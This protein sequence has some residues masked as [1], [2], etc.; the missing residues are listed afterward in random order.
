[1]QTVTV[2]TKN[3]IVLPLEVRKKIFGLKPGR[4][5]AVY[6]VDDE[7]IK[8]KVSK[9]SWVERNFGALANVLPNDASRK[10]AKM[11]KEWDV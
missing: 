4:K 11:R 3:Q 1:M 7:T 9:Q 10:I 5:V 8:V 6:A 2:G